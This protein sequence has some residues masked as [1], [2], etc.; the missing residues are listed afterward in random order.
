MENKKQTTSV[1]TILLVVFVVL[2]LTNNIDWSWWWV[3]SPIWIP[4]AFIAV[5]AISIGILM[6][7]FGSREVHESNN[8]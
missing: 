6:A 2:K 4:I 1:T 8:N 3:L 5:I 7:L